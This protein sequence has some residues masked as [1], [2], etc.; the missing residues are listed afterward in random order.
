MSGL[1]NG[2]GREIQR[3]RARLN[4]SRVPAAA[5]ADRAVEGQLQRRLD[6]GI[7][8][9]GFLRRRR[10]DLARDHAWAESEA[11]GF[12]KGLVLVGRT[13][14]SAP[15]STSVG[16][17]QRR[18]DARALLSNGLAGEIS[19]LDEAIGELE[20]ELLA[21]QRELLESLR[22]SV[23][24][25]EEARR[26]AEEQRAAQLAAR[27]ARQ[28]AGMSAVR[29]DALWSPA[30][31]LGYWVWLAKDGGLF[32]AW[33][34]WDE[35]RME[36]E[37]AAGGD[38]PHTDGRCADVAFGCGVY[39]A[40]SVDVLMRAVGGTRSGRF[41]VGLVG[42]DGK[43]VEHDRGYRAER[44]TVLALAVVE[45]GMLRT[46]EG[47]DQLTAVFADP[48]ASPGF[49]SDWTS[50]PRSDRSLHNQ[51]N[52][53]LERQARRHDPWISGSSRG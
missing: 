45:R 28:V 50:A 9:L 14:A 48:G 46:F 22:L 6:A 53:Y 42:L 10:A 25:H 24:E 41:A 35:P 13:E 39:A 11:N 3:L 43:V 38:L 30:P 31:V 16:R 2:Y 7:A 52:D 26:A 8:R 20:V 34:R 32:G 51:I 47:A 1:D 5:P 40:K 49:G 12:R 44:A 17:L 36:A 15:G 4:G 18:L 27:R 19:E 33:R 23:H 37:C 29:L 21:C